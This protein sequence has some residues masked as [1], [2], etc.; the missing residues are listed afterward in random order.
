MKEFRITDIVQSDD[1]VI[2]SALRN[3][4]ATPGRLVKIRVTDEEPAENN[5][6]NTNE[7]N[8]TPSGPQN[9]GSTQLNQPDN[10]GT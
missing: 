9:Q 2:K 8:A 4:A 7:S 10:A 1:R 6:N 5:E 3:S